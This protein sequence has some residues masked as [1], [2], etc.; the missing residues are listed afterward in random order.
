MSKEQKTI[1]YDQEYLKKNQIGLHKMK[2]IV[3]I[4]INLQ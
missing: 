2:M 1:K 4:K 3:G